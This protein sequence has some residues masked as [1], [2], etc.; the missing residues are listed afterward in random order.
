M[1]NH[2]CLI[3]FIRVGLVLGERRREM[4]RDCDGT[5]GPVKEPSATGCWEGTT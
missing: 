3:V 1:V 2:R 5:C 4:R